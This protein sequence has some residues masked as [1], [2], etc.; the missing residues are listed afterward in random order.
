MP[1]TS[2][3]RPTVPL[4]IALAALV[5][6]CASGSPLSKPVAGPEIPPLPASA[7]QPGKPSIC[8]PTCSD[9]ARRELESWLP[10]PIPPAPPAKPAS[11][12][13]SG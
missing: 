2:K 3:P 9:A 6:S 1:P 12:P 10:T 13:I 7:R 8:L 5:T 4:L 11:A